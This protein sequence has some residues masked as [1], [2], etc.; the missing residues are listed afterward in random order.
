[1]VTEKDILLWSLYEHGAH[2]VGLSVT[3]EKKRNMVLGEQALSS[4]VV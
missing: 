4:A 1:M 2:F 3:L